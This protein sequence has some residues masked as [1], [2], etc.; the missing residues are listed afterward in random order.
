MMYKLIMVVNNIMHQCWWWNGKSFYEF[1]TVENLIEFIKEKI[2]VRAREIE[3]IYEEDKV[4]TNG[5]LANNSWFRVEKGKH[6]MTEY[7]SF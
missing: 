3:R 5:N 4:K 6:Q 1:E 2:P 7:T